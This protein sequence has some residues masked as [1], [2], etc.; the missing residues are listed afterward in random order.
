MPLAAGRCCLD[1]STAHERSVSA[2]GQSI[3]SVLVR[4]P[5]LH[6]ETLAGQINSFRTIAMHYDLL[7]LLEAGHQDV[8]NVA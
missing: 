4:Q 1:G 6:V 7:L 5:E 3:C 8:A 2:S